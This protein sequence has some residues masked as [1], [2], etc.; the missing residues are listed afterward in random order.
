MRL[1]R[2]FFFFFFPSPTSFVS[3]GGET[4]LTGDFFS[5]VFFSTTAQHPPNVHKVDFYYMHCVNSSVFFS[6]FLKHRDVFPPGAL[7]RL[8]EWKG[9]VDLALYASR[10]APEL[11]AQELAGYVSA[12]REGWEGLFEQVNAMGE[13]DGHAAKYV[14]AVANGAQVCGKGGAVGG[15][16]EWWAAAAMGL[17]G[18]AAGG[19]K[20]VRSCG[21]EEAWRDVPLREE[22]GRAQL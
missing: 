16:G 11:R 17:D 3:T 22:G 1:V 9:R 12:R 6:A 14:R 7:R 8:L 20:W 13:D 4:W 5:S 21:F 2:F 10:G 18:V 15:E 19:P